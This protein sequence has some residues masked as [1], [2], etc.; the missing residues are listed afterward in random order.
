MRARVLVVDLVS[1]AD[2]AVAPVSDAGLDLLRRGAE[3]EW[4]RLGGAAP[5]A[6]RGA[7]EAALR[8]ADGV[9]VS[10]WCQFPVSLSVGVLDSLP[11]LKVVAG[12]FDNRFAAWTDIGELDRRG[13]ALVDTSRNMTPT[14][15]EFAFAM[16]LNLLRDIPAVLED[17]RAGGWQRPGYSHGPRAD[18]FVYGDLEGRRVGL[19]GF[20]SINRRYAEFARSFGCRLMACDPHVPDA[21][22]AQAGVERIGDL[23]ALA[24]ASEVFVVGIPPTPATLKIIS[25]DVIRAIPRGGLFVLVTR[26]AVVEQETLWARIRDNGLRAAIDV[27]DPEPPPPDAWF[28]THP[29]C[30][31]SPHVAGGVF[32]CH[33]RCFRTACEDALAVLEGRTPVYRATARDAHIYSGEAPPAA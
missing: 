6:V 2:G 24:R 3:V 31:C 14:V 4:L 17:V 12:T 11:R 9:V 27:F 5:E 26:M 22:L 10:P 16:T 19:A 21:A 32:Y 1:R 7:V 13:V 28:R 18:G 8:D 33:E 15:A 20:G 30:L 25:S 29:N 23:I